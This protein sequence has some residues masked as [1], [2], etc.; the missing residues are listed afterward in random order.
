MSR[1]LL[2]AVVAPVLGA[3]LI[4]P[5]AASAQPTPTPTGPESPGMTT[6]PGMMT[7]PAPPPAT[8][9]TSVCKNVRATLNAGWPAFQASLNQAKNQLSQRNLNGTEASLK[10]AGQ[11]LQAMGA[12]VKQQGSQAN[13]AKLKSTVTALG[14]E[15]TSLGASLNSLNS[16]KSFNP[17]RLTP[18]SHQ[19]ASTC[20]GEHSGAPHP[21]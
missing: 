8:D 10:Q 20:K 7:P 5:A 2:I 16:L 19:L 1:R 9:T 15:M 14:T 21:S 4:A 12:Q 11:Q 17:S 18:L 3:A 13:D 6:S